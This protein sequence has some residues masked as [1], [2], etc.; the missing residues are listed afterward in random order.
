MLKFIIQSS[1]TSDETSFNVTIE[2]PCQ[3]SDEIYLD[4]TKWGKE[5]PHIAHSINSSLDKFFKGNFFKK[6]DAV[7]H[8]ILSSGKKS[9]LPDGFLLNDY[10]FHQ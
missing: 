4:K 1:L 2:Y 5:V 10:S 9:K 8:I 3:Y 7:C 6:S